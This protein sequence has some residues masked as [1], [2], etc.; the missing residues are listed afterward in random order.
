[1]TR[2]LIQEAQDER[3]QETLSPAEARKLMTKGKRS[4]FGNR[5]TVF[6][7]ITFDS[8]VEAR[9]Y[10]VL[11]MLLDA[12]DI[13][14]LKLQPSY[15]LEAHGAPICTYRA[16]FA[17]RDAVSGEDITEDVKGFQTPEFK[18]KRKLF[19]AQYRRRLR[20]T[21]TKEASL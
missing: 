13:T 19:E 7:G 11:Q 3:R 10:R 1:M 17:Y 18:L 8:A 16:D 6:N 5:K 2:A 9:R 21:G 4:K 14:D 20:L 12:G 15:R